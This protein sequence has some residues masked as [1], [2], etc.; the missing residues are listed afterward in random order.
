M[1]LWN[2][3]N[4]SRQISSR[5]KKTEELAWKKRIVLT[6]SEENAKVVLKKTKQF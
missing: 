5:R 2:D 1:Q 6:Y 3:F 4:Y